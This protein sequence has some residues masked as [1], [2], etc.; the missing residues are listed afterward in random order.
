MAVHASAYNVEPETY[1]EAVQS[2]EGAKW[3][4]AMEEEL[5][6]LRENC[7]FTEMELPKGKKPLKSKWVYKVKR[8]SDGTLRNKA[9]LVAKGFT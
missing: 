9:R 8:N 7:T 4:E 3:K 5:Q 6:S 1:R 2:G